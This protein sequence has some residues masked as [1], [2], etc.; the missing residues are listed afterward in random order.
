MNRPFGW[1][2]FFFFIKTSKTNKPQVNLIRTD[3]IWI[4]LVWIFGLDIWNFLSVSCLNML[5]I[6]TTAADGMWSSYCLPRWLLAKAYKP[7]EN[8]KTGKL[9]TCMC[10]QVSWEYLRTEIVCSVLRWWRNSDRA[11]FPDPPLCSRCLV[12]SILIG[13]LMGY[14]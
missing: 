12:I 10:F 4:E 14:L 2:L 11:P 5:F 13:L 3:L 7:K 1:S 8:I 9:D 6:G